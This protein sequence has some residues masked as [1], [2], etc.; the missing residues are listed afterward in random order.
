MKADWAHLAE[1]YHGQFLLAFLIKYHFCS[2]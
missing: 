1:I 2:C